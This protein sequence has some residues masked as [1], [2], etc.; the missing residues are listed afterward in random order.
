MGR[1]GRTYHRPWRAR[2]DDHREL[3]RMSVPPAQWRQA[4]SMAERDDML[5]DRWR[6]EGRAVGVRHSAERRRSVHRDP[7][8]CLPSVSSTSKDSMSGS[9]LPP[10]RWLIIT[11]DHRGPRYRPEHGR[12]RGHWAARGAQLAISRRT[13]TTM[14]L[15]PPMYLTGNGTSCSCFRKSEP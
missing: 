11:C 6:G 15:A 3:R 13:G 4:L 2:H 7:G 10:G 8:P 1:L 12:K 14:S 9:D 5:V